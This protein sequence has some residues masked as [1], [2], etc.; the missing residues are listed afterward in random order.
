M[1][2]TGRQLVHLFGLVFVLL[3]IVVDKLLISAYF[4]MVASFFLLYSYFVRRQRNILMRVVD[5]LESGLRGFANSFEREAAAVPY[6]GAFWFYFSCGLTLLIFP[7]HVALVSCS[8]LAVG[9]NI[10]VEKGCI[11][12]EQKWETIGLLGIK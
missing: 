12:S 6:A 7:L 11:T 10:L 3:S 4:F 8:I 1:G 2:E 5:R 9:L